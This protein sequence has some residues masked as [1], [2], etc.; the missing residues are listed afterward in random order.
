MKHGYIFT[1]A[2][3]LSAASAQAFGSDY[4]FKPGLWEGTTTAQVIEAPAI[5]ANNPELMQQLT[6]TDTRCVKDIDTF[7]K[8]EIE[9]DLKFT[10]VSSGKALID[11]DC[12]KAGAPSIGKGEVYFNGTTTNGS[13]LITMPGGPLGAMKMKSTFNGKYIGAC[14]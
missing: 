5:L 8:K 1:A 4:N 6:E 10:R 7:L 11:L 14:N 13:L 12:S 9:C 3:A 2:L